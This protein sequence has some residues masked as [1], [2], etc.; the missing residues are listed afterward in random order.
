VIVMTRSTLA[1]RSEPSR[2]S[3]DQLAALRAAL[4]EQRSFRIDQLAQLH[5]PSAE[6]PLSSAVPE[7]F[8]ELAAGARA[9]LRDVQAALWRMDEGRYGLCTDCH[10]PVGLERLEILPQAALCLDCQRAAALG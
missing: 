9:A 8:S 6:G 2:P 4:Q 3:D 1:P 7:I 10:A 5:Y